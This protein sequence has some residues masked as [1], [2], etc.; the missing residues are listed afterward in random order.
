MIHIMGHGV[1]AGE[2]QRCLQSLETDISA[3]QIAR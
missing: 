3:R 1:D 2:P